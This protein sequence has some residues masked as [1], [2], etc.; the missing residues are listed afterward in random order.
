MT[1]AHLWY[2]TYKKPLSREDELSMI[3]RA[4]ELGARSSGL[5]EKADGYNFVFV[6]NNW[7]YIRKLP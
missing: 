5:E 6:L 4:H 2:S 7:F 3:R 1:D